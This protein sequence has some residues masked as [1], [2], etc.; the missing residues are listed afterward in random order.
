MSKY[1]RKA[2]RSPCTGVSV[3]DLPYRRL[4]F[5]FP[6]IDVAYKEDIG[7]VRD[8]LAE[9][10]D[11]NPLCLEEPRPLFIF[12]GFDEPAQEILLT[13]WVLNENYLSLKNTITEEIK[14]AFDAAGIEIP[15]PQRSLTTESMTE[16]IPVQ[17]V[18]KN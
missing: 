17:V 2:D 16:P 6:N 1:T 13:V 9:V 8:I 14:I 15:F 18:N 10:A 7:Q 4:G 12:R 5:R 11:K 3:H